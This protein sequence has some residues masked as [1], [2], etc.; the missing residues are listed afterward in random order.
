MDTIEMNNQLDV[1]SIPSSLY[2]PAVHVLVSF[3]SVMVGIFI[4][5]MVWEFSI[6]NKSFNIIFKGF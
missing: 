6:S 5:E 4:S 3:M 1:L 2:L